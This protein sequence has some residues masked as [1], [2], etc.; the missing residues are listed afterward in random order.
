M[1]QPKKILSA[2]RVLWQWICPTRPVG[3]LIAMLLI[4]MGALT[5]IRLVLLM[6]NMELVDA[7]ID[8]DTSL[9][10]K[11]MFN[12]MRFD[13]AYLAKVWI[14]PLLMLTIGQYLP[15]Y[16]R[17]LA[18]TAVVMLS[19]AVPLSLMIAVGDV[20]YFE[21][22]NNHVNAMAMKYMVNDMG[23]ATS[24]IMG[25]MT[26]LCFALS[27]L[28]AAGAYLFLTLRLARRFDIYTPE[29]EPRRTLIMMLIMGTLIPL[30]D[31][32]F[33]WQKHVLQPVN[34]MICNNTFINKLA[35][36]PIEPF[37]ASLL[38]LGDTSLHLIDSHHAALY[39]RTE[40][41]RGDDF[42]EHSPSHDSPWRNVVIILMEST[43]AERMA[44]EGDRH[45]Y[46]P[47]L[48]R[49]AAEGRYY[50][51]AYSTGTHTCYA[52]YSIVSSM[53]SYIDIHPL[54]E[55][56]GISLDTIYEQ[57]SK[58]EEL[59]TLFF[60]THG[61][62]FDNVRDFVTMQGF[63][64]LISLDDYGISTNHVWGVRDHEMFERA[65][66]EL[67]AVAR[68]GERFATVC[69]TCTNHVPY[70][71]PDIEGFNPK[72]T[73][74]ETQALEYADWSV[75]YFLELASECSWFDETLFIITGDHGMAYGNDYEIVESFNHVPLI[76]YSPKHIEPEVRT[77]LVSQMDITPTA[78]SM[79]GIEYDNHTMGIDL[80]THSRRMIPYGADG[81]LAARDD[82]WLYNYDL[83][84]KID[85]LYDLSAEGNARYVNVA[86]EH[87]DVVKAMYEYVASMSQ[88]GWDMHN[89]PKLIKQ[90]K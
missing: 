44:I 87:P 31:R 28:V 51:N 62:N 57:V 22:F 78:M 60:V 6:R 79:L 19:I 64:R 56:M 29:R 84:N 49:L 48:D 21:H 52:I 1:K 88:A 20:P 32:G 68:R 71:V 53:P 37:I 80:T 54:Q 3:Y 89:D 76:F 33:I 65:I 46:L 12:G 58:R 24:M 2:L 69:L 26:Y 66:R 13:L 25:D 23:D 15:R 55:G 5:V 35:V 14:G 45:G 67:N 90:P 30:A 7:G 61:P 47:T 38:H 36:S 86:A 43:S 39:V 77:E 9:V 73:T 81:H 70:K 41:G 8:N 50:T 82:R 4:A 83:Y 34:G 74:L 18:T 59:H 10:V 17:H 75:G 11:Q 16:T 27:A 85:F 72:G 42:T 40:L 63:E